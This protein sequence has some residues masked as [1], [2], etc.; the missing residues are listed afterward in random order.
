MHFNNINIS[1]SKR[2]NNKNVDSHINMYISLRISKKLHIEC[3]LK[4]LKY[5][6]IPSVLDNEKGSNN[7]DIG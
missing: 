1:N 4:C 3:K 7:I 5:G 2:Y 6:N